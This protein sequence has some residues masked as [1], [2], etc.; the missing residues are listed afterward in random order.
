[1]HENFEQ[2]KMFKFMLDN[3]NES[4]ALLTQ[5][6]LLYKNKMFHRQIMQGVA[7][8]KGSE[9]SHFSHF[10]FPKRCIEVLAERVM[11]GLRSL[12]SR[13]RRNSLLDRP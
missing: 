2:Q 9:F 1:M 7:E 11:N 8:P 13:R 4:I 10:R 6:R 5:S 12:F 3:F